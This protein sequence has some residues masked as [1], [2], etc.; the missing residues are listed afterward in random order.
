MGK[1][2]K[3]LLFGDTLVLAG[4]RTSLAAYATLDVT[5]L[6]GPVV[7]VQELYALRTEVV[8]FDVEAVQPALLYALV[9]TLLDL[10]LVGIDV[11]RNRVLVWSGRQ[12]REL[13]TCDLVEVIERHSM[14][15]FLP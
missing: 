8:I 2:L 9:E 1:R 15:S 14:R 7:S 11:N 6:E 10:L 13:S 4:L 5:C 12:L 3:V